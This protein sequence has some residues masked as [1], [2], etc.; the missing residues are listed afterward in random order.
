MAV[1][2]S[3]RARCACTA[4]CTRSER[5]ACLADGVSAIVEVTGTVER[6]SCVLRG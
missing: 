3:V 6:V 1:S 2:P 4:A 5:G